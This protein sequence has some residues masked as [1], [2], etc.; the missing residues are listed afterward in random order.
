MPD[1]EFT[2]RYLSDLAAGT[3]I[4]FVCNRCAPTA[5][6]GQYRRETLLDRFGDVPMPSLLMKVADCG[7]QSN[8]SR[9]CG[10]RFD[11]GCP[12][13]AREAAAMVMRARR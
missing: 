3:M 5:R 13:Y 8:Y 12:D 6:R 9:P 1:R 7:R 2:S 10:I 4:R 11:N